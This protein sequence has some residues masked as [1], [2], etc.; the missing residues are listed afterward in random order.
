MSTQIEAVYKKTLGLPGYSSISF[1]ISV[2]TEISSPRRIEAEGARLYRLL[3]AS[4][5]KEIQEVG[6][7]PDS[8]KFG[9]LVDGK[10]GQNGATKNG[11]HSVAV[12]VA[13]IDASEASDKQK[14][15][16]EKVAKREKFTAEDLDGIAQR[17]FG[18]SLA[19][20]DRKQ[21][22]SFI[23]E[24]LMIAGPPRFR[25]PSGRHAAEANGATA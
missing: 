15:L 7:L 18:S 17:L 3:Q 6:F 23:T 20:L 2:R 5:D 14:A 10:A 19:E 9:I 4:V 25:K 13:T 8:T 1:A 21:T 12:P 11:H 24:L 22:S 16:I